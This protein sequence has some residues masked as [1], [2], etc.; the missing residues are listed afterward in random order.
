MIYKYPD[1]R[2]ECAPEGINQFI[3]QTLKLKNKDSKILVLGSG[4]GAFEEI[5]LKKRFYNITSVDYYNDLKQDIFE[6]V[7]F[8]RID[9]NSEF[10]HILKDKKF[11]V[12]IA[13]EVLEHIFS[14]YLFIKNVK[15][16]LTKNG[17]LVI[18]TPNIES[19]FSR[20]FYLI[21]GKPA[22]F[23]DEPFPGGHFSPIFTHY[24]KYYL[25]LEKLKII[26]KTNYGSILDYVKKN[27]KK[28]LANLLLLFLFITLSIFIKG[29]DNKGISKLFLIKNKDNKVL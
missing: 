2:K 6:K 13:I 10:Y 7:K 18:S 15:K 3:F 22:F 17:I 5:L 23:I 11:D 27:K 25:R 29:E 12:I 26:Y 4:K 20:I 19:K 16:I 28:I 14:P 21:F 1:K 24:L 9:L 8:V